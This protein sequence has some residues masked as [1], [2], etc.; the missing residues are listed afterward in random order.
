MRQNLHPVPLAKPLKN[1]QQQQQQQQVWL[2]PQ[3]S[4]TMLSA[5]TILPAT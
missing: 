5:I 1:Q 2:N 3:A 4:A